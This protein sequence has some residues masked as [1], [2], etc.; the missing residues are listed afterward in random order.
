MCVDNI[1]KVYAILEEFSGQELEWC[2]YKIYSSIEN[3]LKQ[4]N[5]YCDSGDKISINDCA[6]DEYFS[7]DFGLL[8]KITVKRKGQ[9]VGTY[10]I[11]EIAV[12]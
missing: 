6:Y 7:R 11:K 8:K 10:Y 1:T 9:I 12:V 5:L 2:D 4:F 3:A